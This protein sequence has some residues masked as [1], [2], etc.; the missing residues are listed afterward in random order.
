[1]NVSFPTLVEVS[2]MLSFTGN[3]KLTTFDAPLRSVNRTLDITENNALV[4]FPL[5]SLLYLASDPNGNG[6]YVQNNKLLQSFGTTGALLQFGPAVSGGYYDTRTIF[7]Q[8]NPVLTSMSLFQM[9]VVNGLPPVMRVSMYIR[10]NSALVR[11]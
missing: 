5:P 9:N 6:A 11:W 1:V 4:H 7:V 3:P 2:D 8:G 10:N